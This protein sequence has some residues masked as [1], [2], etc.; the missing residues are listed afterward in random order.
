MIKKSAMFQVQYRS[1]YRA[2]KPGTA[3]AKAKINIAYRHTQWDHKDTAKEDERR[4]GWGRKGGREEGDERRVGWGKKGGNGRKEGKRKGTSMGERE[5]DY[6]VGKREELQD[7]SKG[8][9]E[10]IWK[11]RGVEMG[12][13]EEKKR[14][15]MG[16]GSQWRG[17][18]RG[19]ERKMKERG[20]ER[21]EE[22]RGNEI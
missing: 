8:G 20:E 10:V 4:V 18:R 7:G 1:S 5:R 19:G 12:E 6:D 22:M 14:V 2:N 11:G 16:G 17:F 13:G 15:G 9:W 21:R 3:A